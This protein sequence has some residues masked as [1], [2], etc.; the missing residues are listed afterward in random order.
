MKHLLYGVGNRERIVA[1][2][3]IGGKENMMEVF[4]RDESYTVRREHSLYAPCV[5][6]NDEDPIVS[7]LYDDTPRQKLLG[8]QFYNLRIDSDS[9]YNLYYLRKE[10][11]NVFMPFRQSQWMLQSGNTQIKGMEFDD[12]LRLYW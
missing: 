12:P 6:I 9:Y 5:Y 7:K 4:Y 11:E 3:V 1:S 2:E 8:N 10:S